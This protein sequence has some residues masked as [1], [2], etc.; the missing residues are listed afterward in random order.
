MKEFALHFCAH[1]D[2][3]M[4]LPVLG[5][6]KTHYKD[7][8]SKVDTHAEKTLPRNQFKPASKSTFN[9]TFQGV[10]YLIF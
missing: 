5:Q 3:P 9:A 6:S 2:N 7:L 10:I 8:A 1:F 4:F